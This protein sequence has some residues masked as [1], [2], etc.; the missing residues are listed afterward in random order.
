M[1][2][3]DYLE[4]LPFVDPSRM[5]VIGGSYGGFMTNWVVGH[6]DR[7]RAAVT[8]R[9]ITNLVSHVGLSNGGLDSGRGFGRYP[10][11][12]PEWYARVSPLTYAGNINTPLLI[13]HS[14]NDLGPKIEQSEQLFTTLKLMKKTVE[15]VRFPEESHGLSRHGRPDRRVARLKWILRWFDKYLK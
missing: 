11:T 3:A 2:A 9:S 10:W 1:E 8:Q 6:T 5:G 13:L 14:E 12:D 4:Q 15:F 7:F